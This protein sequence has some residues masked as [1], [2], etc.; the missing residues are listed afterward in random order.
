MQTKRW[1]TGS[2]SPKDLIGARNARS[3]ILIAEDDE[4][5]LS[6]LAQ[7]FKVLG[8]QVRS[9]SDGIMALI[10]MRQEIPDICFPI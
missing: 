2:T 3:S 7:T 6:S 10:E 9:A 5:V 1:N 4:S 8:H